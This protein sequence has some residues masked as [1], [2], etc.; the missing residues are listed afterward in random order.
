M[1]F[2]INDVKSNTFLAPVMKVCGLEPLSSVLIMSLPF[3]IKIS[4]RTKF[5]GA[6]RETIIK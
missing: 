2:F 3:A 4:A 5:I 1:E 6:N